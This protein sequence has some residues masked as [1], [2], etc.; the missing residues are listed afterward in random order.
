MKKTKA[1]TGVMSKVKS[2]RIDASTMRKL[3]TLCEVSGLT[4]SAVV[5]SLIINA[6][7]DTKDILEKHK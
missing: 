3:D 5:R 2:F 4:K 7:S 1:K 6:F